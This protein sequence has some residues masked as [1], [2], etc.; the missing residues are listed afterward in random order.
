VRI[1]PVTTR[2]GRPG[3]VLLEVM[4]AL[5]ILSLAG[6]GALQLVHESHALD[7]N[8]REWSAAVAAAEDGMELAK[9]GSS[10]LHGPPGDPLPGGFRRQITRRPLASPDGFEQVTVT[11][12]LPRG[13]RFDLERLARI[14]DEGTERW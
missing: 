13:G 14:A 11:V 12:F 9:L 4:V 1:A 3:L 2:R 10:A 8:A 6:A 5:I 7:D